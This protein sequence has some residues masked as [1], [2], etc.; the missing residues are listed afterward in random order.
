MPQTQAPTITLP[1]LLTVK[2]VAAYLQV[3]TRQVY[4][5]IKN[6]KLRATK[7]GNSTRIA[8]NDLAMF[9]AAGCK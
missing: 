6:E 7:F 8:E 3:S 5:D 9:L 1:K 4:R 2:Q